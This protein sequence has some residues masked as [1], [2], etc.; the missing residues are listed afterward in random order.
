MDMKSTV[1]TFIRRNIVVVLAIPPVV[2][3]GFGIYAK[4]IRR[5]PQK[6]VPTAAELTLNTDQSE[7]T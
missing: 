1:T 3:A 7:E 4:F 5:R 6:S 2:A